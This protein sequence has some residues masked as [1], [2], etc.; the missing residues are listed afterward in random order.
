MYFLLIKI[1]FF[2]AYY[3]QHKCSKIKNWKKNSR[4]WSPLIAKTKTQINVCLNCKDYKLRNHLVV[5]RLSTLSQ[6]VTQSTHHVIKFLNFTKLID[7]YLA[8]FKE[9]LNWWELFSQVIAIYHTLYI[10]YDD[11]ECLWMIFCFLTLL[12]FWKSQL[13]RFDKVISRN[14]IHFMFQVEFNWSLWELFSLLHWLLNEITTILTWI[15]CLFR[16]HINSY[17]FEVEV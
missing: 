11:I 12:T 17:S 6:S 15:I 1:K 7:I 4:K 2:H 14:E 3:S 8:V 9:Q 10:I 16:F 5:S 13:S